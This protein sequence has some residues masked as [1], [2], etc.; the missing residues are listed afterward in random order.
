MDTSPR[1]SGP[2]GGQFEALVATHYALALLAQ[3]EPFGLPGATVERIEFQRGGQGHPLDD[4]IVKGVTAGG[5]TRCL[6]VQAKRSMAFTVGDEN[7]AAVVKAIV[8]ARRADK[9]RKFAAAVERTTGAIENGV[10]EAL[11]LARLTVDATAFFTLLNTKGRSN[12]AMRRFVAA[13]GK[14]LNEN[15]EPGD[16]TLFAVLRSFSVLTF[17]YARPN[18]IAEHYDRMRA[19]QVAA[20][21]QSSNPYDVLFSLVLRTDAIGGDIDRGQLCNFLR[22][23]GVKITG[24]LRLAKARSRLDEMSRFALDDIDTTVAGCELARFECQQQIEAALFSENNPSVIEI[25]GESGVGKS[26]LLKAAIRG[27]MNYSPVLVLAPDRTPPGGWPALRNAFDI[28]ASSEVFLQDLA[29]D[30]GGLVCVDGIDRFVDSGQR[31]TVVDLISAALRCKGLSVI[32]TARP[33]WKVGALEWIREDLFTQ[34]GKSLHLEVDSLNDKEAEALG[35]MA[36]PLAPLL[37]PDHPAKALARN[38]LKLKQLVSTELSVDKALSESDLAANWWKRA[39]YVGGGT[40]GERHARLRVLAAIAKGLI[41]GDGVVDV[42]GEDATAV[43]ELTVGDVIIQVKTDQAKFKHDL[44]ADW[45]VAETISSGDVGLSDLDLSSPPPFWMSRGMELAARRL[46]E[47]KDKTAWPAWLTEL[48]AEGV[49]EGWRGPA[50]LSLVRSEKAESLL[51][52]Y[53]PVLLAGD[54]ER[55]ARLIR[56][57]IAAHSQNMGVVLKEQLPEGISLP[58]GL[59]IPNGRKWPDLIVWCLKSF[60]ELQPKP[61]AAVMELFEAWLMFAV[62]GEKT[63]SPMLLERMADVLIDEL[64]QRDVPPLRAGEPLPRIKLAVSRDGLETARLQVALHAPISP[65]AAERY[66]TVIATSKRP[67]WAIKPLLEFPGRISSAVPGA[68]ADAMMAALEEEQGEVCRRDRHR[69]PLSLMQFDGPF[70]RGRCGIELFTDVLR[71]IPEKGFDLVRRL[72]AITEGSVSKDAGFS[73][74]LAGKAIRVASPFSYGWSRGRCPS[75][76]SYKALA[77]LEWVAHERIDAGEPVEDIIGAFI[78]KDTVSGALLLVIVD[79]VLSH[80]RINS[81]ILTDLLSSPELLA[82]DAQRANVDRVDGMTGG[83]FTRSLRASLAADQ[84][85]ESAL[86]EKTSRALALHDAIQQIP[87]LQDGETAAK[88]QSRLEAAVERLGPWATDEVNWSSPKFMASH[89]LRLASRDN[90]EEVVEAD[91]QGEER[92]GWIFKW[93]DGQEKWLSEKSAA[94]DAEHRRFSNSL[95]IRMAMDSESNPVNVDVD[96]AEQ[97]LEDTSEATSAMTGETHDPED[98]W[99]ARVAAAAFVTRFGSPDVR[100]T[101]TDEIESILSQAVA[102]EKK[103]TPNLRYDVMFDTI[104]LGIAGRLYG[105]SGKAA[106]AQFDDLADVV[107]AHPASAAAAF[108]RHAKVVAELDEVVIRALAR[109]ALDACIIVRRKD[110]D[111]VDIT[112]EKRNDALNRRR[113]DRMAAEKDWLAAGGDEPAWPSP[114]ARRRCRRRRVMQIA[115]GA[116]DKAPAASR[117]E[118]PDFYFD[119]HTGPYWLRVIE[120]LTESGSTTAKKI[121]E[122]NRAWLVETNGIGEDGADDDIER[123]W[124]RSLM[125]CV[126]RFGRGWADDELNRLIFDLWEE[127]SDEAFIDAAASFLLGSDLRLIEGAAEDQHYL[128]SLRMRIWSRLQTTDHWKRH[129]W[130]SK[131]GMEIH[132]KELI[133]VFFFRADAGFG[134]GQPYT[135]GL[136]NDHITPFLEVLTEIASASACPTIAL[137]YLDVLKIISPDIA[138]SKLL[139]AAQTWRQDKRH[140]FWNEYGVGKKV[141]EIALA[142]M[143]LSNNESWMEIAETIAAS[144]VATGEQLITSIRETS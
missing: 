2:A 57:F 22:D 28:D 97:I 3:T 56:R 114:P 75:R 107:A 84:K 112:F 72:V 78:E 82:L 83:Q 35:A 129:L 102:N 132:L 103:S 95:A 39:G 5:E 100:R 144:G 17:D 20:P 110:Y 79:L 104:A 31:K 81:P 143:R 126:A 53:T 37:Q 55:A 26:A 7:F 119:D 139:H 34:L 48:E 8:E 127:F 47:G 33:G 11:E 15:G 13:F 118:R 73:I 133:S 69:R 68:L 41:R 80:A 24:V 23:K 89:A 142:A 74:E 38:P 45:A 65:N 124:T 86:S 136:G 14:H 62:F 101:R 108:T 49:N 52:V 66:L 116:L 51:E 105:C 122:T 76:S 113:T 21:S 85:I 140:R 87:F 30:G 134:A 58:E 63:I 43:A 71:G 93:P 16:E 32:F 141:A 67:A 91:D 92:R 64:Q 54:G 61:L 42:R 138:E 4:I 128:N 98:P 137:L 77:A 9:S 88:L 12:D 120:G 70:V 25:T 131:D 59:A 1:A 10:Q 50:L 115:G 121:L 135:G 40:P 27:R 46:A 109:I 44:Y 125:Q 18:S 99:I 130:S 123:S 36:P 60:E 6:E 90:Y 106:A 29:C 117:L 111:E 19:Q 96:V 94:A